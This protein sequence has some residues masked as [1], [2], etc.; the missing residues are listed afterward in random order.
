L[1]LVNAHCH[2]AMIAFRGRAED[3]PLK[4][5]LEKYMWPMEGKKWGQLYFIKRYQTK[6]CYAGTYKHISLDGEYFFYNFL[7]VV[8]KSY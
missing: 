7:G 5:W 6:E 8:D 3:K 4:E 2:A 1:P